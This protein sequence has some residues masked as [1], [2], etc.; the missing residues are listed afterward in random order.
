MDKFFFSDKNI[1]QLCNTLEKT[2]NIKNDPASK[3]KCRKFLSDQMKNIFNEYGHKKP[4]NIDTIEFM[5]KLNEMSVRKCISIAKGI[6]KSSK[7]KS[8]EK[9]N[10]YKMDREKQLFG[11]REMHIPD[12]S[13]FTQTNNKQTFESASYLNGADANA[14]GFAPFTDQID[15]VTPD[16][17]MSADGRIGHDFSSRSNNNQS[18]DKNSD[19]LMEE[20]N[21][22]RQLYGQGN[23]PMG[24]NQMGQNPMN[25]SLGN[26]MGNMGNGYGQNLGNGFAPQYNPNIGG[27]NQ[28]PQYDFNLD[29]NATKN[30]R[31][32]YDS[33][34][35]NAGQLDSSYNALG[36]F[37][38]MDPMANNG[39]GDFGNQNQMQQLIQQYVQQQQNSMFG[40]DTNQNISQNQSNYPTNPLNPNDI[41][42]ELNRYKD[43]RMNDDKQYNRRPNDKIDFTTSPHLQNNQNNQF[44]KQNIP[45]NQNNSY[46]ADQHELLQKI[47]MLMNQSNQNN[48]YLNFKGWEGGEIKNLE[49]LKAMDT[50]HLDEYIK[51]MKQKIHSAEMNKFTISPLTIQLMSSDHINTLIK[52]I[53]SEIVG[54]TDTNNNNNK[55]KEHFDLSF[56][57][58]MPPSQ[59]LKIASLLQK[60]KNDI[61]QDSSYDDMYDN[62]IDHYSDGRMAIHKEYNDDDT[63]DHED[64]MMKASIKYIT[65]PISMDGVDPM[66]YS[67]YTIDLGEYRNIVSIS[68]EDY[69][70]PELQNNINES[71]NKLS[72]K[73]NGELVCLDIEPGIYNISSLISAIHEG[74]ES[75]I[76][77]RA[78]ISGI[79]NISSLN[80]SV[81]TLHND[82]NS[83]LGTLGFNKKKY[84]SRSS[85]RSE[86]HHKLLISDKI[87]LFLDNIKENEPFAVINANTNSS[88]TCPIVLDLIGEPI[89]KLT[90]LSIKF[91]IG[92]K[93]NQLYN[94]NGR[95]HSMT[96]KLGVY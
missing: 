22:R 86:Q 89:D 56:D 31:Q 47:Q 51:T 36:G 19:N 48:N 79:I 95:P 4:K 12:R 34:N 54:I 50:E 81:F 28:V 77:I 6:K 43:T 16:T 30:R 1:S 63:D 7:T 23:P 18:N 27:T 85:Y 61:K 29:K 74:V 35:P 69:D 55:E 3:K 65:V 38:G 96:F 14:G 8:P 49:V 75:N 32:T 62:H 72:F 41:D 9:I 52:K 5:N 59:N 26:P 53:S 42:A 80:N 33:V 68:L 84:D 13:K 92:P 94:F 73:Q 78:E 76:T 40:F 60:Y 25:D 93:S 39:M 66:S 71:N 17:Y 11:E 21:R 46:G 44:N 24:Q 67:S 2:L 20:M 70:F 10:Q 37:G 64:N 88:D 91:K 90:K 57:D 45:N 82:E 15:N 83:I 58:K 87:Y